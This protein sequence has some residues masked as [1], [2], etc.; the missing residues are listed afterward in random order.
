MRPLTL[1]LPASLLLL[2]ATD[3]G[4]QSQN[5]PLTEPASVSTVQVT[6]PAPAFR[7]WDYQAEA[8]SGAYAMSN[9]WRMKVEPARDGI[10]ASID[11]RRPIHLVA[12][13]PDKFVSADG[14]VSMEFNRG[15]YQEDMIMSYVPDP[16]LSSEVIVVTATLAQR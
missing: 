8:V 6:A 7:I 1:A 2:L 13:S 4:A 3:A 16:R 5:Y 9:G 14:N 12:L 11:K 15:P 10:K